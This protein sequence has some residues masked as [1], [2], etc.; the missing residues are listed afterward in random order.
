MVSEK[1]KR[2]KRETGISTE[3]SLNLC[4]D[5]FACVIDSLRS[6]IKWGIGQAF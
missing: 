5:F 3:F 1:R 4:P 2:G 6:A